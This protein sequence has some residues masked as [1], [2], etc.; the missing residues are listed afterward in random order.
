MLT[1]VL[2]QEMDLVLHD[3]VCS[4]SVSG[5]AYILTLSLPQGWSCA[6]LP[7]ASW[8]PWSAASSP[9]PRSC[10][11]RASPFCAVIG[12]F[13]RPRP[14]CLWSCCFLTGGES[15]LT[16]WFGGSWSS[17]PARAPGVAWKCTRHS[18][19]FPQLCVAVP[20]VSSLAAGHR[21]DSWGQAQPP[22]VRHQ[23]RRVSARRDVPRG[24]PDVRYK[25][26]QVCLWATNNRETKHIK[27]W[28]KEQI[29]SRRLI[30]S[31]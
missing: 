4:A 9:C 21:S 24:N 11:C 27:Y 28:F 30:L 22:G 7:I 3:A 18:F 16:C 1:W 8:S 20:R 14:P 17:S 31:I 2:R 15:E 26:I 25:H 29:M 13:C 5:R 23:K 12:R 6:T 19:C 10:C